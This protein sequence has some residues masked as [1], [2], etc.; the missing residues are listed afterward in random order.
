MKN[1]DLYRLTESWDGFVSASP[2]IRQTADY[3]TRLQE[4]LEIFTNDRGESEH[5]WRSRLQEATIAAD[6]PLIFADVLQRQILAQYQDAPPA[7]QAVMRVNRG[8]PSFD[9]ININKFYGADGR[10]Q[11][12]PEL[13]E[14]TATDMS[15]LEYTYSIKKWGRTFELSWEAIIRD[16]YGVFTGIPAAFGRGATKTI[17][18]YLTNL[19]FSATGARSAYF[20]G[21]GGQTAISTLPLN[22]SNL[23]TAF[24]E[25]ISRTNENSE[26]IMA[27][28][29]YLWHGPNLSLDVEKLL[30]STI[31]ITGADGTQPNLNVASRLNLQPL[32]LRWLPVVVTDGKANTMWG[33]FTDAAEIPA[34]EL[35][36]LSGRNAPEVFMKASNQ[37]SVGGADSSPLNGDYYNDSVA[38]KVRL[39]FGATTIDA[40]AGW[41]SHGTG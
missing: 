38:Y 13:G 3:E 10:L 24:T 5:A 1:Q 8:V 9:A 31:N 14:Y 16:N 21:T 28:P 25:V 41:A 34:G 22:E 19:F 35:G 27:T 29:V 26:P 7:M 33:L 23:K 39:S 18:W 11:E 30:N 15:E 20:E 12:V 6:F 36:F 40:R 37:V 17:E 2:I 4:A 32:L